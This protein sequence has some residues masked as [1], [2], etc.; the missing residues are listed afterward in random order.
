MKNG[1]SSPGSNSG[2]K[3]TLI[4]GFTEVDVTDKAANQVDSDILRKG[5]I[6]ATGVRNPTEPPQ[7]GEAQD[8]QRG[9]IKPLISEYL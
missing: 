7:D 5:E 8:W 9:K 6:D 2:L 4:E 1:D 3:G